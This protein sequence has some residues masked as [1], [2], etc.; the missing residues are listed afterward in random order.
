MRKP[1]HVLLLV[2]L[3]ALAAWGSVALAGGQSASPPAA[4]APAHWCNFVMAGKDATADGSVLMGYNNDWSAN[5]Y[6]YLEII[7][8]DSTRYQYVKLLTLG[9]IP[10]GGVNVRQLGV[11]YGTF[12]DLDPSVL[13]ADPYVKKGYGGELWD[14]LLQECA[15]AQEALDLLE[16]MAV[17]G[18]E[19]GAAGSFGIADPDEAWLFELLGGHHW[20]AQRVPDDA[21]LAHPNMVTIRQIDLADTE[22]FRG[23][24]DLVSFAQSIGRYDPS[25]G[26]F[27]VAWAYGDRVE[28]Q[29]YYDTN[30]LWGAYDSVAPSL[31]LTPT[32][33]YATRPVYVTPDDPVSRQDIQEICRYHYEGTS[34]D[35]TAGYMLMSPHAQTNRPICYSTTDYSAVW[36]L[37]SWMPDD[38][39]AVLWVAPSRPCSSTYIPFYGSITSVPAAFTGRTA[40]TTFRAVAESLDKKGTVGGTTRYGYYISLVRS[41]YGAFEAEC[42]S[43]QASTEATAAGLSSSER[44]TYLTDYSAQRANQALGL[45][46]GLPAQMP[47]G[48]GSAIRTSTTERTSRSPMGCSHVRCVVPRRTHYDFT[49]TAAGRGAPASVRA[50]RVTSPRCRRRRTTPAPRTSRR[51]ARRSPSPPPSAWRAHS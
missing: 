23:S 1:L 40:F 32:M 15:T 6:Q 26:P 49:A 46:Q 28:L 12:T 13:D 43:A 16:Q 44:I 10:E 36:Q 29:T 14:I 4:D 50:Q 25:Q 47:S 51:R 21:F 22:N 7:P 2:A 27:E 19:A 5:N 45:A 3:V 48:A 17:T 30:R 24:P 37:R 34:I 18:F 41:V 38:I 9:S 31:G 20:V 39:G 35:Q 11:N 33:P 42:A 8:G